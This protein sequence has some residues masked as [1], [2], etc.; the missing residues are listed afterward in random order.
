[1]FISR[2]SSRSAIEVSWCRSG[3][4]GST[5]PTGSSRAVG[6][7]SQVALAGCGGVQAV[8]LD[9]HHAAGFGDLAGVLVVR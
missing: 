3:P 8:D 5:Q 7:R 1:M 6:D 4:T 2:P 9:A